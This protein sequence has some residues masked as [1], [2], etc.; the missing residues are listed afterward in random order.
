MP[1][2]RRVIWCS[3]AVLGMAVVAK[4]A[5]DTARISLRV[6]DTV[7]V[8]GRR[9]CVLTVEAG[10][11]RPQDSLMGF[12]LAIRFNPEKLVFHTMLTSGTLAEAMDQRGFGAPYGEIRAYAFTLARIVTGAKPLVAFL[13]D[14]RRECPDTAVLQLLY[15]EFNEEFERRKTVAVDTSPVTV[16]AS[17]ADIPD[18]TLQTRASP[19]E[20]RITEFDTTLAWSVS[21][22]YDTAFR[23]SAAMT[24]VVG[25]PQ[26]LSVDSLAVVG[27]TLGSWEHVNNALT[28][29]WEPQAGAQIVL[30]LRARERKKD[31]ATLRVVTQPLDSCTCLTR[32]SW[33]SLLVLNT[34]MGSS[35]IS[36]RQPYVVFL[37]S[38]LCVEPGERVELYDLVGR[39]LWRV[40]GEN[41]RR[42]VCLRG[43][44][45]GT[46]IGRWHRIGEHIP[47]VFVVQ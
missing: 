28:I 33:D 43:F 38:Q 16:V 7:D 2:G 10:T 26:W 25:L 12:N 21:V 30:W 20:W 17:V 42:C 23:L 15:V 1:I 24:S 45:A 44:P 39:L 9:E 11:V 22:D 46:Y 13:G 6:L 36:Q 32:W 41:T 19:R 34:P 31:T 35:G 29:T 3:I 14:Y 47:V 40:V 5:G 27:A 4:A 8:C 18:R 37:S